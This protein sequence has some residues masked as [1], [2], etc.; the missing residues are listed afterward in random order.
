M[1]MATKENLPTKQ[2]R[3]ANTPTGEESKIP[4]QQPSGLGELAA[5]MADKAEKR[6][7]MV[8]RTQIS[9]RLGSEKAKESQD[10]AP[11]RQS[12]SPVTR[13]RRYA[14]ELWVEIEIRVGMYA[15]PN[16]DSYSVNFTI[17]AFNR[18]YPGCTSVY[19][20][21]AGHMVAFYGKK[22][23]SK[24]GLIHDEAVVASKAI[25]EIPTW[26]GYFARWRVKCVSISEASEIV[27]GCKRLQKE[28][29]RRACLELQKR[30][31]AMQVDFTLSA[32]ARP[33]QPQVAP[34]SSNEDERQHPR[35]GWSGSR[36]TPGHVSSSPVGR[37][38]FHHPLSSE[39]EG[40]SS[41]A[42]RCDRPLCKRCGSRGSRKGQSGSDS[43]D[44]RSSLRRRKKK[45]GFSSKIQIP[46]FGGK[47]RHPNDVAD[48]F[49]QWARCIT[50]YR[51][52]YEDSY[53]MPLVVSSLKG[54]ASDVF[55]WSR[56]VTPG[57]AQDL[58][59]LLQMLREH[60]CGSYTFWE[61]RNMVKNLRQR[62]REDAM[63]FMIRV[64]TSVSNLGKDWKD[65]LTDEELQS[66]QYE[67]SLNG[68][69]EEIRHVL[70]SEIAR[71]GRLTPHQMYE[72]V[73]KYETYV[74][75]NKRLEG[76]SASPHTNHQRA[77]PQTS[78]YKPHFHKT[79]AFAASVEET[80]D[81]APTELGPSLPDKEDH[82]AVETNQE[83]DEGLFIP[84][85]LEEALG[86]MV[87]SRLRWPALCRLNKNKKGDVSS[88][89]LQIT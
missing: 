86:V 44:T 74:A 24:A 33:F 39:D 85:F 20:G 58:S 17:D 34:H 81:T 26:M 47:K 57:E 6:L 7:E 53:L 84:S 30:F 83:D 65:Q 72:A 88:V 77:V 12:P 43:D 71:H 31:S 1:V 78:G 28:H 70:D 75:R 29:L 41:D 8:Q 32:T 60:Y 5:S 45:D 73:K 42:S 52:Y 55:D 62:D 9:P 18:A 66:L 40:A 4:A 15:A 23:N 14:L 56:S 63:D 59:T 2:S 64:G 61:Q 54:D 89:S 49:R 21:E 3:S 69:K 67:V 76:K 13:P 46:E 87:T 51:D 25:M 50:Y 16:E 22:A 68:V 11:R 48:A 38:P 36:P 79:T 80:T 10:K 37:M 19:L 82:H 35:S 27:A